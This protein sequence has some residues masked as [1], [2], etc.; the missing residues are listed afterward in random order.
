MESPTN[1]F[2]CVFANGAF[3]KKADGIAALQSVGFSNLDGQAS[4]A[5]PGKGRTAVFRVSNLFKDLVLHWIK[6]KVWDRVWDKVFH[7]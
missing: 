6:T 3:Y 7:A 2:C 5:I 4:F 1:V